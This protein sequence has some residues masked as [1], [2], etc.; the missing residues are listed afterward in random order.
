[1]HGLKGEYKRGT[2]RVRAQGAE[3]YRYMVNLGEGPKETT[4]VL[5]IIVVTKCM[6][7]VKGHSKSLI[8]LLPVFCFAV[9]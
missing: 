3:K 7:N 9:L 8:S 1:M 4:E 5:N 2:F 6:A